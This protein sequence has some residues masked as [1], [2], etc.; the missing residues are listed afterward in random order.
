MMRAQYT[1]LPS[2]DENDARGPTALNPASFDDDDEERLTRPPRIIYPHD[3]RFDRPPPPTWQ[4]GFGLGP[5]FEVTPARAPAP[6]PPSARPP[7]AA[8]PLGASA[9]S[10][11]RE[12]FEPFGPLKS[13]HPGGEFRGFAHVEYMQV[14]DA[15][16]A[17]ESFAEEPLYMLDRNIRV[18]FAPERPTAANPPTNKL[19]FYDFRGNEETLRT[20]LAEFEGSI[21][22]AHFLRSSV[23]G[24]LAGSGFVEFQTVERATQALEAVGGQRGGRGGYGPPGGASGSPV[25]QAFLFSLLLLSSPLLS[26]P[27]FPP[28]ST[29]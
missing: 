29:P 7:R 28:P 3:P 9:L 20:A 27:L 17:Y 15:K 21:V 22:K 2:S 10:D 8:T 26:S 16:A 18:D 19:Y 14:E 23:T 6:A 5:S 24:E 12:K 13:V 11:I 25:Y 4:T 1:Q